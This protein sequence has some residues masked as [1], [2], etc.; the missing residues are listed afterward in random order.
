MTTST[1]GFNLGDVRLR[2]EERLESPET[3]PQTHRVEGKPTH[4]PTAKCKLGCAAQLPLLGVKRTW[5]GLVGMSANDPKQ[6]LARL[7]GSIIAD[8]S[9]SCSQPTPFAFQSCLCG[10]LARSWR[11]AQHTARPLE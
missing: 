11:A 8:P 3:Q 2:D 6:T 7:T 1:L 10:P 4:K 9:P 5:R